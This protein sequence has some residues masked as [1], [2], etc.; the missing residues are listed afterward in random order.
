MH[1]VSRRIL[2]LGCLVL[3]LV[4]RSDSGGH[5]QGVLAFSLGVGTVAVALSERRLRKADELTT[6][7]IP[8]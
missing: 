8:R 6:L 2:S 7:N 5:W 3:L 1:R 4:S